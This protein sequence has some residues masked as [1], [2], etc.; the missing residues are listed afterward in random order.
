[1]AK[2]CNSVPRKKNF[3]VE[4][5]LSMEVNVGH[6]LDCEYECETNPTGSTKPEAAQEEPVDL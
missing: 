4:Y 6:M 3:S 2:W 5:P 1:M